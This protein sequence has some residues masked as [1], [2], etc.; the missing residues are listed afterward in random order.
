M[1]P[2]ETFTY[3]LHK[4]ICENLQIA[5]NIKVRGKRYLVTSV[6]RSQKFLLLN[7]IQNNAKMIKNDKFFL[8]IL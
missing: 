3:Y 6:N 2:L 8:I 4:S 1:F 7:S 5:Q